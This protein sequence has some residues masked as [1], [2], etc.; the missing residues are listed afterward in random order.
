[1]VIAPEHPLTGLITTDEKR[2]AV[3]DYI[4]AASLKSDLDRTD[5]AK[6]KT[7]VFTGRYAINPV[8]HKKIPIWVADY[9]LP[10]MVQGQ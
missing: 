8:N 1:M 2:N 5:L 10:V 7:G 3:N 6:E 9:V 4:K